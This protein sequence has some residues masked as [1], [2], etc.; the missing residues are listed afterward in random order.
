MYDILKNSQLGELEIVE[1]YDYF[2]VPILFSCQNLLDSLYIVL[3]ADYLSEHEMWLYSEVSLTR[4]NLIRSG[5]VS[6]HDAFAKPE[7]GRLLKVLIPHNDSAHFSSEYIK[8]EELNEEVF[9]S[10]NKYL[11]SKKTPLEKSQLR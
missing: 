4:L 1:V 11:I 10:V 9:P 8:S 3:F 6:I 2:D 5:L 7:T